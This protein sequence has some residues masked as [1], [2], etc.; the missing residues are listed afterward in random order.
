MHVRAAIRNGVTRDEI[1][2]VLLHATL[3]AGVPAGNAAFGSL[4][5]PS[6]RPMIPPDQGRGRPV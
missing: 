1:A 4:R 6:A 5:R 2:E 3:Y